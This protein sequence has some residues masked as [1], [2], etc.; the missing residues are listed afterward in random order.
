MMLWIYCN[1]Y[2]QKQWL[3]RVNAEGLILGASP[4]SL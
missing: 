1:I 3:P 4:I 2:I